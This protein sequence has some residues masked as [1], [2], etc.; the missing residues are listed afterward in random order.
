[1]RTTSN[2]LIALAIAAAAAGSSRAQTIPASSYLSTY[3]G[4]ILN[5]LQDTTEFEGSI[6]ANQVTTQNSFNVATKSSAQSPAATTAY[7]ESS[8]NSGFALQVGNLYY[9]G[10]QSVTQPNPNQWQINGQY[11]NLNQS[12]ASIIKPTANNTFNFNSVFT[13]VQNENAAYGTLAANSTAS[14][15]GNNLT[16]Q[17]GATVAASGGVAVFN[18]NKSLLETAN[19]SQISLNLNGA[20]P[21]AIVINV[22]GASGYSMQVPSGLNFVGNGFSSNAAKVLWNFDD[23]PTTLNINTSW[24]GS[25]LAPSATLNASGGAMNGAVAVYNLNAS[26]EIHNPLWTGIPQS[27]VSPVPEASTIGAAVA[28]GCFSVFGL[29]RRRTEKAAAQAAH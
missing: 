8:I 16:F 27:D 15:S 23:A 10:S 26:E 21:D 5:K 29:L 1:M 20:N 3:D 6:V 24:F 22:T 7:I 28:L 2:Q 12:G 17:V 9:A 14:V 11:I 4:I 25:V 19:L 13:G 18:I